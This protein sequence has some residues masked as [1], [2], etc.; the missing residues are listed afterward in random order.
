M[1]LSVPI[2]SIN[3]EV[4]VH[5]LSYLFVQHLAS[6]TPYTDTLAHTHTIKHTHPTHISPTST[7]NTSKYT[8]EEIGIREIKFMDLKF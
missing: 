2:L 3:C 4:D 6:E 7:H 5:F 1:V 8:G